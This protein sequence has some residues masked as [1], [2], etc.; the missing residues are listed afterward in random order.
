MN[1]RFAQSIKALQWALVPAV[2]L[3]LSCRRI[4]QEPP[5]TREVPEAIST[6]GGIEMVRI[7]AGRFRMGTD[8]GEKDQAPAHEV[9]IDALLIDR[10]ETSQRHYVRLM[11]DNGSR[12]KGDDRPAE[13]INW[14]D[15][16]MYCNAR[17]EAEGLQPCYNEDTSCNYDASGYRLPTEAEWEYACR[18]GNRADYSFGGDPRRLKD[19]AWFKENSTKETHPVGKKKPNAFGLHDMHGN[20]AEWCSDKYGRTYYGE[21]PEANPHGPLNGEQY[22][23]RGGSWASSRKACRSASRAADNPGFEDACFPRETLGFRCVRRPHVPEPETPDADL[24]TRAANAQHTVSVSAVTTSMGAGRRRPPSTGFLYGAIYL[25]HQTGAGHPEKPDRL[26]S[27]IARLKNERLLPQLHPIQPSPA[28]AR[29]LTSVHAPEY[30]RRVKASCE[31]EVGHVD[32]P[33]APVS[34]ESYNAAISAVGGVLVAVDA[35]VEGKVDNAFCA[36]RPPGHHALRAA[37]MGFCL[38]NNAAIAAR[39]IQQK[40]NLAKV[41]I[42]DWD[43]HHGNGTQAIFYDDPTVF[44]FGVHQSPLY[45]GTGSATE[46]GEGRGMN[47]TLNV[48]L[49]AHSG[50]REYQ[51]VFEKTLT[52]AAVAFQPDFILISAGFD[53]HRDDPLGGMEVTAEGFAELTRI[54]KGIAEAHCKG[55]LVS[56]L[57]GGYDLDGL[58][59]SVESHLRVLMNRTD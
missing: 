18:A 6:I 23:V 42:V 19:Y 51:D 2:L 39:Y 10:Y 24:E 14:V 20:V 15:A 53:A 45:P 29:W 55:R 28:S 5:A 11:L 44:Y 40:H 38:F 27:I 36:V 26:T 50:D 34:R 58:V 57:E 33:D 43:V 16:A 30:V 17:S 12:F 4:E 7:P 13:M 41:L 31:Q 3:G 49:P 25:Q 59:D 8:R 9:S 48:P 52:P 32:S 54:V 46:R 37:A 47:A 21:S 35:V 56:I 22:V 1:A